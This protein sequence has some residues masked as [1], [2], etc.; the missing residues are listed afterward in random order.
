MSRW[1]CGLG[2][3]AILLSGCSV[4]VEVGREDSP[5]YAY[6][7]P[8]KE[9]DCISQQGGSWHK[10]TCTAPDAQAQVTKTGEAQGNQ[11]FTSRPDCPP[12]TDLALGQPRMAVD[13]PTLGY[14]CARNL[15]PPHPGDPGE[16]GGTIDVGDCLHT[17]GDAIDEVPC[18]GSGGQPQYKI[19]QIT[20]GPCPKDRTDASFSLGST[21]VPGAPE[22]GYACAEKL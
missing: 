18:N 2:V 16:G 7:G 11:R 6:T 20:P 1:V 21:A 22:G 5:D 12:G 19:F 8:L 3:L 14:F 17:E 13:T 4:G 9:L 10:V 15:K